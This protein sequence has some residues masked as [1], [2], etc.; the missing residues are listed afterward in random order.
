MRVTSPFARNSDLEAASHTPSNR[1]AA[2][3]RHRVASTY[4]VPQLVRLK[5]SRLAKLAWVFG[6]R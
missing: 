4:A 6:L 3:G 2:A 1:V 5:S